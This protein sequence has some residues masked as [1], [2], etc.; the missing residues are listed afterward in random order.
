[1]RWFYVIMRWLLGKIGQY[2]SLNVILVQKLNLVC[3]C[4]L[5]ITL[6]KVDFRIL[7]YY[8]KTKDAA[9]LLYSA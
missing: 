7:D 6:K 8:P 4:A 9:V 2:S 5:R 1:M 3:Q